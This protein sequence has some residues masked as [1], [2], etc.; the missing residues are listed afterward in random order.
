MKESRKPKKRRPGRNF[1]RK[2]IILLI[3]LLIWQGISLITDNALLVASP[4]ESL[5][6]LSGLLWEK[7]FWISCL[8]SMVRIGAGFLAGSVCALFLAIVSSKVPLAEEFLR[9]FMIFCK[10]V[11]VAVFTVLILIWW[12]SSALTAIICFLV[13]MPN[14]YLNT[15]SG[16]KAVDVKVLEVGKVFGLPLSTKLFYIYRPALK[17]FVES[18]LEL[19]L[20][21]CW[22]S[23]V[24]AEVIGTPLHSIGGE[25]Y[26]AKIYLDTPGIFAWSAVIIVCSALFE[27]VIKELIGLFWNCSP[28]CEACHSGSREAL[29]GRKKESKERR[30]EGEE[31]RGDSRERGKKR[32][33]IRKNQTVMRKKPGERKTELKERRKEQDFKGR[34][35]KKAAEEQAAEEQAVNQVM[36]LQVTGLSKSFGEQQVLK[37]LT[38]TYPSGKITYLTGA[39]GSGKTTLF[40]CLCGLETYDAGKVTEGLTYSMQFQEDRLC[41]EESPV[42]NLEMVMGSSKARRE[43][44][45]ILLSLGL[46]GEALDKPCRELS[47]GMKRRVSL[48]R[49]MEADRDCVLLDEPYTGMDECTRRKAENYIKERMENRIVLMATHI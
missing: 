8:A 42:K 38:C 10:T 40:R 43:G 48:A 12:G 32:E 3:W 45:E 11:P 4:V 14:L 25:L 13:V 31:V 26:L 30:E 23:G 29:R 33:E 41:E 6:A 7:D 9:S 1:L 16:I 44:R 22:K 35:E 36:F 49:A 34:S 5:K 21:M 46:P 15:L 2:G 18:A 19:S 20:G 39:S 28:S 17:P 27:K 37:E 47:G 24:A